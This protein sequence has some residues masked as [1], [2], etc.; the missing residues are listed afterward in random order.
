MSVLATITSKGQITIPKEVRLRHDLKAGDTVEFLEEGGRT[1][2]RPRKIRAIDLAGILGRP[3]SGKSLAIE[4][5][6]DAIADAVAEEWAEFE[7][8]ERET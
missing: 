5:F 6:D 2:V 8:R 1:Y 3:P 7:A 4:E